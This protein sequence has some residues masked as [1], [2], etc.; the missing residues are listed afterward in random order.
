M[1]AHIPSILIL[2]HSFVRRLRDDLN[3]Q[4]DVRAAP[5]FHLPESGYVSL[6]GTGGW[7]VA[8]LR[9]YDLQSVRQLSHD[10]VILEIGTN[11]LSLDPPKVA[12]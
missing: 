2:G 9:K 7:T 6:M 10:I 4:F 1:S 11:N 5:N 8:K 12:G 3:A